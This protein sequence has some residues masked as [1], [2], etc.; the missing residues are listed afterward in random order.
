MPERFLIVLNF[1]SFLSYSILSDDGFLLQFLRC[2]K[3]SMPRVFKHYESHFIFRK[4]HPEWNDLSDERVN[5]CRRLIDCGYYYPLI[6]RAD[7]GQKIIMWNQGK[8]DMDN[9]PVESVFPLLLNALLTILEDETA[10]VCGVE[11]VLNY[12]GM[13]S[14]Y[15]SMFSMK[16]HVDLVQFSLNAAPGRFKKFYLVNMPSFVDNVLTVAKLAMSEKMRNR[17]VSVK[18]EN[19]LPI[20]TKN[21]PKELGGEVPESQMIASFRRK[22][23]EN[24][25]KL[26]SAS[27]FTIDLDRIAS[28][29]EAA[30]NVGSFR[31]LEID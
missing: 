8:F 15:F 27:N 11:V 29:R 6:A 30:E 20:P 19:E 1:F 28:D 25:E 14:K 9:L 16:H 13:S 22:F 4:T 3:Y 2:K 31:K 17:I 7:E 12:T 10:Q 23:D 24:V 18:N 5:Q 26:K 21:L